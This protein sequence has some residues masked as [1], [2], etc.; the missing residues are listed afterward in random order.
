MDFLCAGGFC[1]LCVKEKNAGDT[2]TVP[3]ARISVH[4]DCVYRR[5]DVVR[6]QYCRSQTADSMVGLI[7]LLAGIP[8][9]LYWRQE[10]RNSKG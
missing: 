3:G 5:S 2:S 7:L 9:Y 8:F 1:R 4:T 6:V 10:I